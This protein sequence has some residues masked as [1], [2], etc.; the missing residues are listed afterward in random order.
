MTVFGLFTEV[1]FE[2][3]L[4]S[5]FEEEGLSDGVEKVGVSERDGFSSVAFSEMELWIEESGFRLEAEFS[6]QPVKRREERR[7]KRNVFFIL[8]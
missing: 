3:A 4:S 6:V 7:R 1:S 8:A 2:E 5:G